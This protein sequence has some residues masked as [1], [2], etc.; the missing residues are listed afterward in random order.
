MDATLLPTGD[1]LVTGG[2]TS[3][4]FSNPAGGVHR[5]EIWHP[6]TRVWQPVASAAVT[7]IYH[8][9]TL[10]LPDGRVLFT[11]S[12]D[13][14]GAKDEKNYEVYSPPYLF[15]GPRPAITGSLPSRVTYG[16]PLTV[17]TSDAPSIAKVTLLRFSS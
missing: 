1:V 16:Q 3:G 13:A 5:A 10:L 14:A 12:G 4:G 17:E 6:A 2:T 15:Q 11:G 9:A 8:G 7:R